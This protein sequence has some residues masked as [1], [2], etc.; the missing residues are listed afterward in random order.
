MK[1]VNAVVLAQAYIKARHTDAKF[2]IE[3]VCRGVGYSRRQ[4]DR[5][6]QKHLR[7]TLYE[8]INAVLLSESAAEL[9]ETDREVLDV[10]LDCHFGSHEGYTRSFARHFFVTPKEYRKRK[11]A[12][13]LFTQ[14]P[15][16]HYYI[17]KGGRAM[18][19]TA[20]CTVT[21]VT[22]PKRKLIYLP[23]HGATGYFDYCEEM[24][25]QWEGLLNS[26][27]EK[28]DAAALLELPDFLQTKGESKIA[29]GVEVPPDYEK[30]LPAGYRVAELQECIMLYFQSG[31][32]ENPDDFG[33][34]I[35]QVLKAAKN[36]DF[37]RY[38]YRPANQIAPTFNLG[39][40]PK[41]GARIA[42]PVIKE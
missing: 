21:P 36:Y 42:I 19:T 17:L 30:P 28:F 34:V 32:Y 39:A 3:S 38:G 40:D 37:E 9:L 16:N 8:Y 15:V 20:I 5:L 24:G 41:I 14:H 13:P 12:I 23:S 27:P 33:T 4:L 26:I 25:C 11:I 7:M 2:G 1:D 6:F 10:A 29:S 31:P 35:A 18:E 22:R